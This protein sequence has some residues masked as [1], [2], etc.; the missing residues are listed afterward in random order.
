ENIINTI[1]ADSEVGFKAF[2]GFIPNEGKES[3]TI[4]FSGSY[5]YRLRNIALYDIEFKTEKDIWENVR[6]K[7][8]DLSEITKDFYK[9]LNTDVA[10][11]KKENN[12]RKTEDFYWEG[13]SV[14]VL[15]GTIEGTWT[16][17]YYSYP[18]NITGETKDD[19]DIELDQE[20]ANI[21][22]LYMAS[23]LIED[24]DLS[25]AYYIRQQ[26]DVAKENLSASIGYGNKSEFIDVLGW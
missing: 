15:D 17:H 16:I 7:R 1:E 20:V 3:V 4:E 26:Y 11:E 19:E 10:I 13:D 21:L 25:T 2:K 9:L 23:Q 24:D 8:Y 12:Y 5:P 18:K 22:P 14:L 6:Y